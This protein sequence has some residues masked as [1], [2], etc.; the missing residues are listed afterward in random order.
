MRIN[1][2]ALAARSFGMVNGG[3]APRNATLG[4]RCGSNECSKLADVRVGSFAS[5]W[6]RTRRKI[7]TLSKLQRKLLRSPLGFQNCTK[8]AKYEALEKMSSPTANCRLFD[9]L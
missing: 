7:R 2:R 4:G 6:P 5:V 3:T 9:N 8:T 1:R